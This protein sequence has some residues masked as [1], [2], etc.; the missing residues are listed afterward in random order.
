MRCLLSACLP[1]LVVC[2]LKCPTPAAWRRHWPLLSQGSWLVLVVLCLPLPG[3]CL[4]TWL[5]LRC[6]RL[7]FWGSWHMQVLT[8]AGQFAYLVDFPEN[9]QT[10]VMYPA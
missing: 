9:N 10:W 8:Y 6:C 7:S 3:G 5:V 2:C 1:A 4:S